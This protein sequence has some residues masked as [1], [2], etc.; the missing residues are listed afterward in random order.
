MIV[1]LTGTLERDGT[2]QG[3]QQWRCADCGVRTCCG[4]TGRCTTTQPGPF[5]HRWVP[6]GTGKLVFQ[7]VTKESR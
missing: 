3:H 6:M 5:P 2:R 4:D 7:H 1:H